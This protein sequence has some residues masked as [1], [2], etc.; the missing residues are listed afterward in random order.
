MLGFSEEY[1]EKVRDYYNNLYRYP[2]EQIEQSSLPR[3]FRPI[4]QSYVDQLIHDA[5]IKEGDTIL[6]IGCGGV[7]LAVNIIQQFRNVTIH[8]LDISDFI[9]EH[10][11]KML[12]GIHGKEKIILK[13]GDY[14]RLAEYYP[15]QHFDKVIAIDSFSFAENK[16][17]LACEI[18]KVLNPFGFVYVRDLFCPIFPKDSDLYAQTNLYTAGLKQMSFCEY[19]DIRDYISTFCENRFLINEMRNLNKETY[20][21]GDAYFLNYVLHF[22][23]RYKCNDQD[24]IEEIEE[25]TGMRLEPDPFEQDIG[26][27]PSS[28]LRTSQGTQYP[29]TIDYLGFKFSSYELD[30]P[31]EFTAEGQGT[32]IEET[33]VITEPLSGI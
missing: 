10:N 18:K 5:G 21:E 26:P 9:M 3:R 11:L 25:K 20:L 31:K 30:V 15:E 4:G 1:S 27:S 29:F 13:R 17:H 12:D 8:C 33:I 6:D 7:E 16:N 24:L 32:V 28:I 23:E 22:E 14:N 19:I 2:W